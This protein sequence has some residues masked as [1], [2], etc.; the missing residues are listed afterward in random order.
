MVY[1][2]LLGIRCDNII[3]PASAD[4]AQIQNKKAKKA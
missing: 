1:V 3:V 4:D 2:V